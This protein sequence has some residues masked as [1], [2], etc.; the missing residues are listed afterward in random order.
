MSACFTL[1]DHVAY[2]VT[3]NVFWT[4]LRNFPYVYPFLSYEFW[5]LLF[6]KKK[7]CDFDHR[8]Q[9]FKKFNL[10]HF[11]I[12]DPLCYQWRTATCGYP[13]PAP[14]TLLDC[15]PHP[16]PRPTRDVDIS[17]LIPTPVVDI[18]RMLPTPGVV[19]T[20]PSVV[21]PTRDFHRLLLSGHSTFNP[22][23][24]FLDLF[25]GSGCST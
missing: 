17:R 25:S 8:K 20:V 13:V 1:W 21:E 2:C 23:F 14:V 16:P 6:F 9:H 10:I 5:H 24:G 3:N 4:W 7:S 18:S 12:Y 22:H 19:I 11:R 15:I